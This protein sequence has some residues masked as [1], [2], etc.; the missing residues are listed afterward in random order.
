MEIERQK[1][2]L[3]IVSPKARSLRQRAE[4]AIAD[5]KIVTAESLAACQKA[6]HE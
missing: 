1:V 2:K 3:L 4:A 6:R 5:L